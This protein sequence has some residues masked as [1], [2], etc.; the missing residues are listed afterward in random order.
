MKDEL[1]ENEWHLIRNNNGEWICDDYVVE[2]NKITADI[3][4]MKALRLGLDLNV[5]NGPEGEFWCYKFQIDAI[6]AV[7]DMPQQPVRKLK[8]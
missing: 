6:D 3:Y 1:K 4:R 7:E 8:I 2:M 5:Q